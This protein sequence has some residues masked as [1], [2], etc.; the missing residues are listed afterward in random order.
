MTNYGPGPQLVGP[1]PYRLARTKDEPPPDAMGPEYYLKRI[2]AV[3][4]YARQ[5]R[6]KHRGQWF[7]AERLG[8]G[9]VLLKRAALQAVGPPPGAPLSFFDAEDLSQRVLQAGFRLACC[10]DLFVHWSGSRTFAPR[11]ATVPRT[12]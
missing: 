8:G 2:D 11:P 1:V 6:D 9:C 12:T 3:D 10:R 5:W 7:E 4:Q